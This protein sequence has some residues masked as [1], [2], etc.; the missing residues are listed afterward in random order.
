MTKKGK[1]WVFVECSQGEFPCVLCACAC[2][3][4]CV[5]CVC[6]CFFP[7]FLYLWFRMKF[8]SNESHDEDVF[9]VTECLTLL[10]PHLQTMYTSL[11]CILLLSLVFSVRLSSFAS[12]SPTL[13]SLCKEKNCHSSAKNHL[14][15]RKGPH[16]HYRNYIEPQVKL[17]NSHFCVRVSVCSCMHIFTPKTRC[18]FIQVCNFFKW[19]ITGS[20]EVFSIRKHGW[21][22]SLVLFTWQ[23]WAW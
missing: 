21:L 15:L 22:S 20:S 2:T 7:L 4:M 13:C 10:D 3:H 1:R 8:Y 12:L 17:V 5:V 23:L 6:A 19:V 16:L 18:S 11:F 14:G 9:Y